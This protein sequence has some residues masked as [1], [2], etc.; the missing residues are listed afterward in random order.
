MPLKTAIRLGKE[1]IHQKK[2]NILSPSSKVGRENFE[3]VAAAIGRKAKKFAL[4][5]GAKL[6]Y[7]SVYAIQ[8]CELKRQ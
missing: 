4:Y 7:S 3:M 6:L 1:P 8:C 2:T 5:L